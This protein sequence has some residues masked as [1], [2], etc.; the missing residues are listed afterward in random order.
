MS[1]NEQSAAVQAEKRVQSAERKAQATAS[2]R[3]AIDNYVN[4]WK[5]AGT[6]EGLVPPMAVEVARAADCSPAM[7]I[8]TLQRSP[9]DIKVNGTVFSVTAANPLPQGAQRLTLDDAPLYGISPKKAANKGSYK[10]RSPGGGPVVRK[11]TQGS[12]VSEFIRREA[13]GRARLIF[14]DPSANGA[15]DT[16]DPEFIEDL[17]SDPENKQPNSADEIIY[18]EPN[19]PQI[20]QVI[21]WFRKVGF[22]KNWVMGGNEVLL[23]QNMIKF[24]RGEEP[25]DFLIWNCIGFK[26]F[27]SPGGEFPTCCITNNLDAAISIYFRDRVQEIAQILATIGNPNITILIPSNEAFDERAW[28]YRQSPEEREIIINDA[29]D[30]LRDR[31]K[32]ISLPANAAM[33][34]MRWDDFLQSRGAEKTPQDY[35]NEGETRVRG[36]N[37]F[38]RILKKGIESGRSYLRNNG[39]SAVSD[40][41]L[42][43]RQPKYYGVYAGEGVAFEEF[44]QKGRNVVVINLEEFRPPQM[45]Y[46]GANNNLSIVTPVSEQEMTGY[47]RWEERQIAKRK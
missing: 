19:G 15:N 23:A 7:V 36:S 33:N 32:D 27:A 1:R 40:E 20:K 34:I 25:V 8:N 31:Y 21:E 28:Q 3:T 12:R 44:Q 5:L 38:K 24:S 42:T 17:A 30:G 39:I 10:Q 4:P 13:V 29:V 2:I 22:R 6:T 11:R 35:S 41:A 45:A 14:I 37:N 9:Y 46:L 18:Q 43:E 16:S 47:Y 26:W